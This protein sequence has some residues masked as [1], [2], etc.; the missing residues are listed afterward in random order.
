MGYIRQKLGYVVMVEYRVLYSHLDERFI[1]TFKT[2]SNEQNY[3]HL[4]LDQNGIIKDC[5]YMANLLLGL[6]RGQ[7]EEK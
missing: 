1:V 2:L 4:I 5:S 6:D 3:C 7:L